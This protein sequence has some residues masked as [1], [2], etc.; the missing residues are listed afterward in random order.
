MNGC[1]KTLEGYVRDVDDWNFNFADAGDYFEQIDA[2]IKGDG[3]FKQPRVIEPQEGEEPT[4]T[5]EPKPDD[6]TAAFK[7]YTQ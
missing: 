4:D 7:G 3:L 6:F 1:V 5:A 2:M